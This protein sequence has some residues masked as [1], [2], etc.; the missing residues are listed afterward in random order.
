MSSVRAMLC[1]CEIKVNFIFHNQLHPASKHTVA[2]QK[3][4]MTTKFLKTV[5]F[6]V[7]ESLRWRCGPFRM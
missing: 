2:K 5:Y 7:T 1:T 3:L 4:T 6:K